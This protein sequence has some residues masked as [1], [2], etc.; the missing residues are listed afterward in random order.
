[1]NQKLNVNQKTAD[2][3]KRRIFS[4]S[5]IWVMTQLVKFR[6]QHDLIAL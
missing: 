2:S 3:H 5:E 6:T 1:M 4:K